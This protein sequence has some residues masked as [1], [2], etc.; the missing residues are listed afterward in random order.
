MKRKL[1]RG[2]IKESVDNLPSGLCFALPSGM[3]MLVNRIMYNLSLAIDGR[4]LQNAE[5]FWHTLTEGALQNGAERVSFGAQPVIRLTDGSF[6]TFSRCR[7]T[8]EGKDVIQIIA[9]DTTDL[10]R[11]AQRLREDNDALRALGARLRSYNEQIGELTKKEE[12]LTAKIRIHD[13]VGSTLVRTRYALAQTDP[14][15]YFEPV[16]DAWENVA[17][18]LRCVIEP[19][20]TPSAQEY[21]R[22]TAQAGG[23]RFIIEG[24]FPTEGRAVELMTAAAGEAL[25]NAVRHGGATA[26]TV[27]ITETPLLMIARFTNNG[28]QPTEPIAEGGGIGGLRSKLERIGGSVCTETSPEFCLKV[29]IPRQGGADNER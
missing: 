5:E 27:K 17:D 8:V 11:L 21:L 14:G 19:K 9:A 25:T 18:M 4:S 1:P 24:S 13:E 16:L 28:T 26:L 2:A 7:I 23:V 6:R 12:L 20:P 10:Y 15:E 3:P 22:D 29:A